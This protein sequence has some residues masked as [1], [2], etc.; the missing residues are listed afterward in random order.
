MDSKWIVVGKGFGAQFEALCLRWIYWAPGRTTQEGTLT[1][2]EETLGIVPWREGAPRHVHR[3]EGD[4]LDDLL[5]AGIVAVLQAEVARRIQ[6]PEDIALAQRLSQ[7]CPHYKSAMLLAK[8][9]AVSRGWLEGLAAFYRHNCT[10]YDAELK[11]GGDRITLGLKY[12]TNLLEILRFYKAHSDEILSCPT[13]STAL[14][15]HRALASLD[16]T[17]AI[18]KVFSENRARR[19]QDK[20]SAQ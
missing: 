2:G 18:G 20:E 10:S 12:H 3:W 6:I 11:L 17:A 16:H 13:T 19:V 7:E 9:W 8:S 15:W 1:W 14:E 5:E 4:I